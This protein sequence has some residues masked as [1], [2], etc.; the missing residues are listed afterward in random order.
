MKAKAAQVSNTVS[1]SDIIGI[2]RWIDVPINV[3]K[4]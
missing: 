4:N 2:S 3:T 1:T